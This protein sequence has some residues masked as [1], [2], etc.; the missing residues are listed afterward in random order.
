MSTRRLSS[1]AFAGI[2]LLLTGPALAEPTAQASRLVAPRTAP[3]PLLDVNDLRAVLSRPEVRLLDIRAPQDFAAGHIPGAVNT[4]YGQ[5][6]GPADNP[7]KLPTAEHL[8]QVVQRAGIRANQHVIVIHGGSNHT[9]FGAAARVYWTLKVGGLTRLSVV[10]GG[11]R[12]WKEAG[13]ELATEA[14]QVEPSDFTY[15]YDERQIVTR[16]QLAQT[17]GNGDTARL[18]DARPA[19]FFKG[20]VKPATAARYGTLP[21]ADSFDNAQF[22][23][24]DGFRLKPRAELLALVQQTGADQ[25][26]T[27]SFCNTGH[28]AAT[29]WFVISEIAGN[30]AARMYPAS[31]VEWSRSELPMEN[32]PSRFG[33]LLQDLSNAL[34]K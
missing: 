33:A 17:L 10:D 3:A 1:L 16:E 31:M 7:G 2:C 29:N 24:A 25:G 23:A 12:A 21:G 28:W 18:L 14:Q 34:N 20:E 9:D 26:D 22:F 8:T 6:R 4:P 15:V 5:Y 30:K 32:Q 27:V 13:G 19:P 11:L